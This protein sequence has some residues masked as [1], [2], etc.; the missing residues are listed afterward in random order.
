[1]KK[2]DCERKNV[3]RTRTHF[4]LRIPGT[5]NPLNW[6]LYAISFGMPRKRTLWAFG[7]AEGQFFDNTVYFFQ[8]IS[9]TRPDI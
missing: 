4:G 1:M 3:C 8:H 7:T 6:L 9:R 2:P 5:Y